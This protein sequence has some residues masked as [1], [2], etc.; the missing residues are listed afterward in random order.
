MIACDFCKQRMSDR[1]QRAGRRIVIQG[2]G[3]S[4][5]EAVV[6]RVDLHRE[7][8]EPWTASIGEVTGDRPTQ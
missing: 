2:D 6:A 3:A 7:C 1:E 8:Y 4:T 5:E